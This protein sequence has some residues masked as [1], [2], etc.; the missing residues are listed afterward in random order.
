ML[1]GVALVIAATLAV[2]LVGV[3]T[4]FLQRSEIDAPVKAARVEAPAFPHDLI[5]SLKS[6]GHA[7][8]AA[9]TGSIAQPPAKLAP[10]PPE[11]GAP[12]PDIKPPIPTGIPLSLRDAV[13][14]GSPGAEYELALR[15]FEGRG[16]PKDP[17]AAA[18]WFERAASLGL[19]PAQYRLGA[20]YEKGVGVPATRARPGAGT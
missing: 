15:L 10:P 19:A 6:I 5:E 18:L 13:S 17:Q 8:D 1:L 9:P 3:R 14:A 2:R 20:L 16:A 4:P 12:A 11:S 7:I